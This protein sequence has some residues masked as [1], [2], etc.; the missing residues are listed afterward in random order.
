VDADQ[1]VAD[2]STPLL[3]II[4]M[5]REVRLDQLVDTSRPIEE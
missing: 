3:I 4:R 2:A 5:V 1:Q